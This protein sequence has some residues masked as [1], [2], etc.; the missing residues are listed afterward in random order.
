M[1]KNKLVIIGF[2]KRGHTHLEALVG[3]PNVEV[4]AVCDLQKL[5]GLD[6]KI[7]HFKRYKG[8]CKK[9][10]FD[11]ALICTPTRTHYKIAS[12]MLKN[13]K[14]I[15][16]EKP[17]TL[18]K[19]EAINLV[20]LAK[21][22]NKA[23]LTGYH[24]RYDPYINKVKEIISSGKLGKI[25]TIRARQ[26]HNWG[27]GRP[28]SW[29][30][31]PEI[32]G[33]G[34]IIDNGSH[35]VD[36]LV[37]IF[38]KVKNVCGVSNKLSFSTDVE[39]NAIVLLKFQNNIIA[40]IEISWGD[41]S[42]RNNELSIWGS[43]GVLKYINN[44]KGSG[45]EIIKYENLKKDPWNK[46][47]E[48]FFYSPKGIELLGKGKEIIE[49]KKMSDQI[50]NQFLLLMNNPKKLKEYYNDSNSEYVVGLMSRIYKSIL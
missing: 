20:C 27:Y 35:Y 49:N 33:G 17:L 29:S 10:E 8:M 3:N 15:M 45:L 23:C 43:G 37:N 11:G 46:Y 16:V 5:K 26:S 32:S 36:L 2:G 21:K 48:E 40:S 34:T 6:S 41:V 38:G 14:H 42:G 7:K 25:Y 9:I 50:L 4:V 24:L 13:G 39:D 44:N 22:N 19:Q 31:K 28:F 47:K 1:K 12:E 30:I 18:K